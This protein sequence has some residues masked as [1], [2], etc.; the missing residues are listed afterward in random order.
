MISRVAG[1]CFWLNRYM[2]RAGSMATQSGLSQR[3]TALSWGACA[4]NGE[5]NISSSTKLTRRSWRPSVGWQ[6]ARRNGTN[7]QHQERKKVL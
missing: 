2:E 3:K 7:S 1:N 6:A 4:S 5:P